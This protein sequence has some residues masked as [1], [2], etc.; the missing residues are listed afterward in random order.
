[1]VGRFV[2]NVPL[3]RFRST[4]SFLV[5]AGDVIVRRNVVGALVFILALEVQT[6]SMSEDDIVEQ[7][8]D[9]YLCLVHPIRKDE[10]YRKE[11]ASVIAIAP[12]LP[13]ELVVAMIVGASWRERLLGLCIAMSKPSGKFT[14][15]MLQSLRDPRCISIVPACAALA[16]LARRGVF[17]MPNSFG[18]MFD[19][20][21]F[22]GEV[23]WATD[24]AM[25]YAGLRAEDVPG[26]GPNYGQI[27]EDQVEVYHWANDRGHVS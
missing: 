22:D 4:F 12:S 16:V 9:A 1:M 13:D 25:F 10:A 7:T 2:R 26:R 21:A 11:I 15:A 5:L 6:K 23:G 14:E 27:F 18:D 17:E 8:K 3:A 19:R 20:I 24:K